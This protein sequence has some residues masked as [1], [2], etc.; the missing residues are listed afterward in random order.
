ML[1]NLHGRNSRENILPELKQEEKQ[2]K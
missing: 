1:I 2:I